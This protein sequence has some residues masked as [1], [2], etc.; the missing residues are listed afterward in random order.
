MVLQEGFP[1]LLG[2]LRSVLRHIPQDSRLRDV[3]PQFQELSVN[4]RSSP[5]R[6]LGCH[7]LD[8]IDLGLR[9]RWPARRRPAL[10]FPEYSEALPVPADEGLRLDDQERCLP[11]IK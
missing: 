5:E 9:D 11:G 3:N 7:L 6:I 4:S 8:Q 1:A 10:P 2:C